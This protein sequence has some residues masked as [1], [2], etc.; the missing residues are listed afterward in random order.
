V[1]RARFVPPAFQTLRDYK[2]ASRFGTGKVVARAVEPPADKVSN[3]N[4]ELTV[5]VV[6]ALRRVSM[7]SGCRAA[8][9]RWVDI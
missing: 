7:V 2:V 3:L 9:A 5:A 1:I 8:F 6:G 4:E